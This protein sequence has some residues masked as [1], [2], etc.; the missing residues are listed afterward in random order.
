MSEPAISFPQ[1]QDR[2]LGNRELMAELLWLFRSESL[3]A[4]D[5]LRQAAGRQ[6]MATA[7]RVT[8]RFKSSAATIGATALAAL[9]AVA[10]SECVAGR[11]IS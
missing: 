8:H 4:L 1:L 6:D 10:E 7:R 9:L 2:T 11:P 3:A 5:H